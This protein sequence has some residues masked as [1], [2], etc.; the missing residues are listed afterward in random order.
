MT[1]QRVSRDNLGAW[2][3]KCNPRLTD[4]PALQ[5]HGV[6]TWCVQDNYRSAL[7]AP[8]QPAVLWV[9]GSARATP[10]P[11]IWAIGQI[12]G[13]ADWQDR[14]TAPKYV[15]PLTLE[16]LPSPL[17]RTDL[18]DHPALADIEVIQQPQ[19]SN[20]SYLTTTEYARLRELL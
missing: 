13:P 14:G 7:F 9:S 11:G 12:T 10:I 20:P 17:P 18:V 4:L 3:F 8:G 15:V 5:E 2:L 16:F 6:S 1:A 19:M